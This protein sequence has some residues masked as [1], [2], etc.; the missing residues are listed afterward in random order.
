MALVTQNGAVV[1][2]GDTVDTTDVQY[3]GGIAIRG[4]DGAMHVS[5]G[6]GQSVVMAEINPLS[7]RLE[8]SGGVGLLTSSQKDNLVNN[9][10]RPA[11]FRK[12]DGAYRQLTDPGKCV[13]TFAASKLTTRTGTPTVSDVSGYSGMPGGIP[14][15]GG[16]GAA[17]KVVAGSAFDELNIPVANMTPFAVDN[18]MGLL[19]YI[20]NLPGR[21]AGET[22]TAPGI[23]ITVSDLTGTTFSSNMNI[24]WNNIQLREGYNYLAWK[25]SAT[26]HPPGIAANNTGTGLANILAGQTIKKMVVS[27]SNCNVAGTEVYLL[28]TFTGQ[29]SKGGVIFNIDACGADTVN[30]VGPYMA[31]YGWVGTIISAFDGTG[32]QTLDSL[33]PIDF[34]QVKDYGLSGNQ[35]K[36][37]DL[38]WQV[39]PHTMTHRRMQD[40]TDSAVLWQEA[41][42]CPD[43]LR[44]SGFQRGLE[45]YAAPQN[46]ISRLS[47]DVMRAAGMVIQ[48]GYHHHNMQPMYWGLESD[49]MGSL[50]GEGGQSF[51]TW[52]GLIEPCLQYGALVIPFWHG[53]TTVGDPADGSG[54][55]G[56]GSGTIQY[57]SVVKAVL[58]AVRAKELA[59]EVIVFESF[60]DY[61]YGRKLK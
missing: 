31:A 5:G 16:V 59:G 60:D 56:A 27:I 15:L 21:G 8:S 46:G 35:K 40:I 32:T 41:R 47:A 20:K 14:A 3:R 58:D 39:S 9:E 53:V 30:L 29:R 19:V 18:M 52:W 55:T 12:F 49:L 42:M 48:R 4:S 6:N 54:Y 44:S 17:V 61:Y 28:G 34:S 50:G 10:S 11:T 1:V 22:E 23:A 43:Y 45:F 24:G 36:M 26:A 57:W 33:M 51:A 13:F 7:G 38:G 2:T 25:P 37:Y